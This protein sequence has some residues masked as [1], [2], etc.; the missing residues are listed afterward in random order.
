MIHQCYYCEQIFNTKDKLYQHLEVHAMTKDQQEEA[1]KLKLKISGTSSPTETNNNTSKKTEEMKS[2][3]RGG[4]TKGR[5]NQ[6]KT[7]N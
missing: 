5:K 4:R 7:D 2:S 3:R 1:K 6:Q